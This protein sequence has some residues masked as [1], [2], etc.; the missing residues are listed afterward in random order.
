MEHK[1]NTISWLAV[2]C[3]ENKNRAVRKMFS[4]LHLNVTR[5]I[6]VG[7][8]PYKLD[9][10]LQTQALSG[11]DTRAAVKEIQLTPAIHALF[12]KQQNASSLTK[13]YVV[14][15]SVSDGST[16]KKEKEKEKE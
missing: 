10:I 16:T 7:F 3:Y 12:L 14:D 6:C 5:M 8:G 2:T 9:E 4:N 13:T 1:S 11:A 15:K